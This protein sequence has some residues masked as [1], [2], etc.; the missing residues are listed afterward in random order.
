MKFKAL[1]YN[2]LLVSTAISGLF[3]LPVPHSELLRLQRML[4]KM[5]R[6]AMFGRA[7]KK[8][9]GTTEATTTTASTSTTAYS[10]MSTPDLYR[11]YGICSVIAELR[12]Q[13]LRMYSRI[14][15]DTTN[16]Q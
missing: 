14:A 13:R 8:V 10:A 6:T 11:Y 15:T 5:A 4:N 7:T 2:A 3:A 1:V 9:F 12:V 16:T